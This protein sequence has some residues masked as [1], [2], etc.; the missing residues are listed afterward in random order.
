MAEPTNVERA[1]H[2]QKDVRTLGTLMFG[3]WYQKER[4]NQSKGKALEDPSVPKTL[5]RD[6]L[7][8]V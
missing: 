3:G 5:G 2:Q 1:E 8:K 7:S 6:T 4:S